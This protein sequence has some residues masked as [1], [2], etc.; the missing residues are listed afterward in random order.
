MLTVS[1]CRRSDSVTR[2]ASYVC[3]Y[4]WFNALNT[5]STHRLT[6][7]HTRVYRM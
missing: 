4:N 3:Q 6:Q 1:N 5:Q 7:S 2:R